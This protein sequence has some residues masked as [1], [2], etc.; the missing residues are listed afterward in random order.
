MDT[1]DWRRLIGRCVTIRKPDDE[2]NGLNAVILYPL[3]PDEPGGGKD[4]YT[5]LV[6]GVVRRNYDLADLQ[7]RG[8]I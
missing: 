4:R 2:L 8:G 3:L 6:N 1:T 5:V 7:I